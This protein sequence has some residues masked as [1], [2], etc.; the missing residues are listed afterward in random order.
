[1]KYQIETNKVKLKLFYFKELSMSVY[2]S[3]VIVA[4]TT[5]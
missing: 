5:S 3:V 1:M 4:V 2:T